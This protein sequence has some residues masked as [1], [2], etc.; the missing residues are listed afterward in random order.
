MS[1]RSGP[2]SATNQAAASARA[3][4]VAE[5]ERAARRR[6]SLILVVLPLA[7][8][9]VAVGV[10][11]AVRL[12]GSRT[13]T[14]GPAAVA[15]EDAVISK[16]VS[17]PA[18]VLDVIG[19]GSASP[20]KPI[21]GPPLIDNGLPR[22][23]Y[24]GAEYCPYCAAERWAMVV[25]LSRFGTFKGLGQTAS[26][27]DI[28]LPNTPTLSFH[29]SSFTSST[30]S[31][32]G[33]ETE[34]NQVVD[35]QRAALDTLSATDQQ[36]FSTYDRPPYVD[37]AS[38]GSIPFVDI[39]GRYLISGASFSPKVLQ[40]KTHLEVATALSDP[41]SDIAKG[42]DGTANLITAAICA[43]TNQAPAPVCGAAGVQAAAKQLR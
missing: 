17:V 41:N 20:P 10:L 23:L 14:A 30:V 2:R 7:V 35:G 37:S 40:H 11:V 26:A 38:A 8:V 32:T 9:L 29:G 27:A 6:R 25:A 12:F 28:E 21:S 43:S 19:V 5:Q 36:T 18:S 3:R 33:V 34:S 24:V 15:G 22:V 16:V 42:V 39:G 13:H 4:L 1:S 31:F